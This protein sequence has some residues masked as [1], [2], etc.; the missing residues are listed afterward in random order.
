MSS[1]DASLAGTMTSTAAEGMPQTVAKT[2]KPP[3]IADYNVHDNLTS[4]VRSAKNAATSR[5]DNVSKVERIDWPLK[6]H[7]YSNEN[8]LRQSEHEIELLEQIEKLP[9]AGMMGATE[10]ANMLCMLLELMNARRVIEVGVFR[11]MTTLS[12]ALCLQKLGP[13]IIDDNTNITTTTDRKIVALDISQEFAEL[14][15]KYWEKAKVESI[16]DLRIGNAVDSLTEMFK[17]EKEKASA[18]EKAYDGSYDL[19]F[20]DADKQSYDEYYELSLSLVKPG[21]LIVVD[22]TLWG[23]RVALDDDTLETLSNDQELDEMNRNRYR[24][25]LA[26]KRLTKKIHSDT[27]VDRVCFL[28]IADGVTICKKK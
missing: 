17:V 28:T 16:I 11:G 12:M 25:A 23:G 5:D 6:L 9:R 20:I 19:S 24:D 1:N 26:I 14:G 22:N 7:H 3:T 15:I 27:R 2:L 21:G 13:A 4:V 10:E 18:V 8:S